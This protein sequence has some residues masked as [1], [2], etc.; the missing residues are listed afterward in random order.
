ML[1][2]P[3]TLVVAVNEAKAAAEPE[4]AAE[5]EAEGGD[6]E[7]GVCPAT[8]DFLE[9]ASVA[10][11]TSTTAARSLDEAGASTSPK[12]PTARV[13]PP[14]GWAGAMSKAPL[15]TRPARPAKPP[16][17]R[18]ASPSPPPAVNAPPA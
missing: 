6:A 1:T 9:W 18:S 8:L 11:A 13:S 2:A 16:W 10:A 14:F 15:R 17:R 4:A 12:R 7:G 5:G 3:E